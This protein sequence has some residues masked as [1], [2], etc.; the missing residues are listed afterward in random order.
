MTARRR[1]L[2]RLSAA[3]AALS[4]ATRV[5]A[6]QPASLTDPLR[7]GVDDALVDS[8]LAGHLQRAFGQDTGVAVLLVPGPATAVLEALEHG[9]RDAALTN[10]PSVEAALD[11]QGLVFDRQFIV[12]SDF[13]LVGPT[14]LAKPLA[15]LRHDMAAGAG[16][17]PRPR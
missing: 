5:G 7:L 15:A 9:E 2:L 12:R 8:G 4:G 16:A 10:A 14:A 17:L 1:F 13:V 3:A 6:A 11:K